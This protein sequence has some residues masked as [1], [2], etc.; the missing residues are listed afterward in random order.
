MLGNL[1]SVLYLAVFLAAGLL[2]ARRLAPGLPPE[3]TLVLA[4]ALGLALLAALPALAALALGFTL[5]AAPFWGAAFGPRPAYP[6]RKKAAARRWAGP[7]G[8]ACCPCWFSR[9]GCC[10]PT[11]CI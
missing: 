10:S 8:S 1:L 5:A 11:R 2:L 9:C 3:G 4:A 6:G 7:S